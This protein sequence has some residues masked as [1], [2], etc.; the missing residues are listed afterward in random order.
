M[1]PENYSVL[2]LDAGERSSASLEVIETSKDCTRLTL[3]AKDRV[4]DAAAKDCFAALQQLRRVLSKEGLDLLCYGASRDVYPSGMG[5]SMGGGRKAYRNVIGQ[6][7]RDPVVSIFD[8]GPEIIAAS[9]D[10]QESFHR[11]WVESLRKS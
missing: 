2:L 10:E 11:Q 8:S 6:P 9:V 5:R 1:T 3:R 7:A 4:F